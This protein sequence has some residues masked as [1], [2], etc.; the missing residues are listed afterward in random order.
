M[1][2]AIRFFR[3]FNNEIESLKYF[4]RGHNKSERLFG[5]DMPVRWNSTYMILD[6]ILV[7]AID[8]SPHKS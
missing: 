8:P 6:F 2:D 1:T 3:V 4:C 7:H 5:L